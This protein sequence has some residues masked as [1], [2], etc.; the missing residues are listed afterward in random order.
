M[1]QTIDYVD[2]V[3]LTHDNYPRQHIWTFVGADNENSNVAI[4]KCP[5]IKTAISSIV[6]PPPPFVGNDYLCDTAIDTV[7]SHL[8]FYD[9]T[10]CG[11]ELAVVPRAHAAPSTVLH[12]YT[13]NCHSPPLMI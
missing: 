6:P 8:T 2:G 5:C 3:S 11:M 10:H 1:N 13:S 12:G 4:S 7:A 9:A